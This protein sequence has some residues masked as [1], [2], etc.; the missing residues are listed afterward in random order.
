MI[1]M[2]HTTPNVPIKEIV[3]EILGRNDEKINF[4]NASYGSSAKIREAIQANDFVHSYF[5]IPRFGGVLI[6]DSAR[7]E[8]AYEVRTSPITRGFEGSTEINVEEARNYIK[9]MGGVIGNSAIK[10]KKLEIICEGE[11]KLYWGTKRIRF[12][13]HGADDFRIEIK[14]TNWVQV[15]K[16][17]YK[18]VLKALKNTIDLRDG[19]LNVPQRYLEKMQAIVLAENL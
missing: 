6:F 13:R 3:A 7:R 18:D 14:K 1:Q 8:F 15:R 17:E 12:L 16:T 19:A 11:L 9:E 10:D 4:I 5:Y 2:K